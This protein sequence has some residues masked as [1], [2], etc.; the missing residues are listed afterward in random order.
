MSRTPPSPIIYHM[1]SA[2]MEKSNVRG[3]MENKDIVIKRGPPAEFVFIC[4]VHLDSLRMPGHRK[5]FRFT[6]TLFR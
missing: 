5:I 4:V 2:H 1:A 3:E 6:M